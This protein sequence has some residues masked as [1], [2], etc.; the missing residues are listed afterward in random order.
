MGNPQAMG[1]IFTVG[2]QEANTWRDVADYYK[3]HLGMEYITVSTEE[4]RKLIGDDVSLWYQHVYDRFYDRVVDNSKILRV[5]GV[6]QE[7]LTPL[8]QAIQI[9]LGG[10]GDNCPWT[11]SEMSRRMDAYLDGA[12]V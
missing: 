6:R 2:S 4:Y 3:K 8:E 1:E 11:E 5:S 12:M 7:E 9:E 10:L